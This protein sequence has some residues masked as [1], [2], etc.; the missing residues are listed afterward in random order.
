MPAYNSTQVK[1][2]SVN[3]LIQVSTNQTT[4]SIQTIHDDAARWLDEPG[5]MAIDTMLRSEGKAFLSTAP[6][7]QVGI[8]LTLIDDWR[9]SFGER[10]S[11][12]NVISCIVSGGNLVA[13]NVYSNNP[14][15]PTQYTQVQIRQSQ[16][17]TLIE[18]SGGGISSGELAEQLSSAAVGISSAE[19]ADQLADA[20]IVIQAGPGVG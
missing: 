7:E 9:L 19:L 6:V 8:T 12:N 5:N 17:P 18:G 2:D 1:F 20:V 4:V 15:F 14:I 10:G 13:E 16:A 3:K 11:S